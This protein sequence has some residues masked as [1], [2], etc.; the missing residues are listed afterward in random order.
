MFCKDTIFLQ[1]KAQLKQNNNNSF[2][3]YP[4]YIR[5]K[6]YNPIY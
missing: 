5:T 1:D 6:N 4:L 3:N 2:L